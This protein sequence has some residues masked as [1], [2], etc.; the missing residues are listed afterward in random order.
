MVS[1]FPKNDPESWLKDV[2]D[3]QLPPPGGWIDGEGCG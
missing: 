1:Y 3:F 2:G